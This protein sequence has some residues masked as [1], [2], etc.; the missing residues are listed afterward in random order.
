MTAG[1]PLVW[2]SSS[3]FSRGPPR[4]ATRRRPVMRRLVTEDLAHLSR[5][6]SL[7]LFFAGHGH[8]HVTSVGDTP[9]KT[10][11]VIPVEGRR[12]VTGSELGVY[13]Q[14][15]V[16]AYP[17]SRQTPDLGAFD[18]DDR[19]DIV[20]RVAVRGPL[21]GR[22]PPRIKPVANAQNV[23]KPPEA[24]ARPSA[25]EPGLAIEP[26]AQIGN[27]HDDRAARPSEGHCRSSR[28]RRDS[29][30]GLSAAPERARP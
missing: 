7:V 17:E 23:V 24:V 22:E 18:L 14:Q 5:E 29:S 16:R 11:C 25:S 6:D 9:I 10:G 30:R 20:M 27:I 13:L 15:R 3:A 1:A 12:A 8:T 2:S 4:C 21:A 19:R 26:S 28:G